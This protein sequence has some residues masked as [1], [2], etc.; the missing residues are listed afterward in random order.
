MISPAIQELRRLR[1]P[2]LGSCALAALAVLF[3]LVG[4]AQYD[5]ATQWSV[6]TAGRDQLAD[7]A[8]RQVFCK[9]GTSPDECDAIM[10]QEVRWNED[11]KQELIQERPF[12]PATQ[13]PL[14]AG[15]IASGWMAS[16]FGLVMVALVSACLVSAEWAQGTA[17]VV[18]AR[19]AGR[20][21][22]LAWKALAVWLAS[23]LLT[24]FLWLA[25]A[26]AGPVL[27]SLYAVSPRPREWSDLGYA[28]QHLAHGALVLALFSVVAVA[29]AGLVRN[30]LAAFAVTTLLGLGAI[31]SSASRAWLDLSPAYWVASWMGFVPRGSWRDHLG[32]SS[33]PLGH[34]TDPVPLDAAVGVTG[35]VLST[36]C[37]TVV[38]LLAFRR[39]DVRH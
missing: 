38:A 25:L 10:A 12:G 4:L 14:A 39:R 35:I 26:A 32:P 3:V 17:R 33:F 9:A 6:Y 7:P 22:F 5:D 8:T 21:R 13:D 37:V 34:A 18:L 36:V 27:R 29:V 28:T 19:G 24:G 11:F 1:N 2:G 20:W 16:L 23:L 31:A 15:G 30:T